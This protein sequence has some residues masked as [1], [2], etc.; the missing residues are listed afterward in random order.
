MFT[1]LLIA[2]GLSMDSFAVSISCGVRRVEHRLRN[3]AQIAL[4][5]SVFQSLAAVAGFFVGASFLPLVSSLDH[6]VAFLMLA[7]IGGRMVHASFS[8]QRQGCPGAHGFGRLVFLSVATSIDALAVGISFAMLHQD[9]ALN[10]AMIALVTFCFSFCGAYSGSRMRGALG[11]KA[12]LF[13]GLVLIAIGLKI[14]FEHTG[15]AFF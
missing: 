14:L 2:I 7:Y 9:I 10:A 13:G 15:F 12:E 1:A 11:R 8:P 3:A 4:S 6:W 5:F